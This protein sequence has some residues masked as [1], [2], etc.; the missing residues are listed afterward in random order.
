MIKRDR[1]KRIISYVILQIVI[2]I[3]SFSSV[4]G[5]LAA[6]HT[7]FSAPFVVYYIGVIFV[8]GIYAICWQQ[9]I[10]KMPLSVAYIN[11]ATDIVWGIIWGMLIFNEKITVR[12][13]VGAG[14]VMLGMIMYFL[15]EDN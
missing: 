7:F 14:I 2:V 15:S 10:K 9:I 11:R 13:W 1:S 6:Q 8:L 4:L 12:Q 3:Y 5:K